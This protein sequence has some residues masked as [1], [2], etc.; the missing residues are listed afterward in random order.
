MVTVGCIFGYFICIFG[1]MPCYRHLSLISRM[2]G[3]LYSLYCYNAFDKVFG[4]GLTWMAVSRTVL[5]DPLAPC[6]C[7]LT[8]PY[9]PGPFFSLDASISFPGCYDRSPWV[10]RDS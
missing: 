2:Q 5:V 7:N 9:F 10:W 4:H 6:A 8:F 3:V 1:I